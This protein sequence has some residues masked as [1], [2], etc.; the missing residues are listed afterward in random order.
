MLREKNT[1]LP[2]SGPNFSRRD[3]DTFHS[4]ERYNLLCET[5]SGELIE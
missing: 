5:G 3:N 4:K 1:N 2:C